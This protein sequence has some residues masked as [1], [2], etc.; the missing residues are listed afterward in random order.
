MSLL[1]IKKVALKQ[2]SENGYE[3]ASMADIANVVGIKKQS[4]YTHFKGKD[5]LFLQVCSDVFA[6]ELSY[7]VDFIE[8]NIEKKPEQ[9]LLDFLL[10]YIER[11]ETNDYTKFWI[12][13]SF[14]PP[15]HLHEPVMRFVYEFL[16]RV[17]ELLIPILE[18]AILK[19]EVSSDL[20]ATQAT[21]AFMGVLDGILVEMLYGGLERARK[22][23]DASWYVLWR[24]V[25]KG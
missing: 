18:Q 14:F 22:R 15:A 13:I 21:M 10:S 2:F 19:G 3:G 20:R 23:L 11:Y 24:G 7:V 16:D 17:E 5:E 1:Q 6:N 8:S 9:L 12:R 25:S 4:I